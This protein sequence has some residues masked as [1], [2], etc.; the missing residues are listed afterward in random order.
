MEG[1]E[2]RWKVRREERWR[3]G[4]WSRGMEKGRG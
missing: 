1:K 4:R 2:E 3:V